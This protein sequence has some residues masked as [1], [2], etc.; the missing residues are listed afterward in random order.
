MDPAQS[1]RSPCQGCVEIRQRD[2]DETARAARRNRAGFCLPRG[3]KLLQLHHR[4]NP[5]DHRR[6]FRG[7]RKRNTWQRNG[8]T[9]RARAKTSK[10]R[11]IA[12]NA[13]TPRAVMAAKAARSRAAN[14]RSPSAFRKSARWARRFRV[15]S[16]NEIRNHSLLAEISA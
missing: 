14:R 10:E 15:K 5:A 8:N 1:G 3:A 7:L 2:A 6:L 9:R 4:R 16:R 13:A 12:T 11:Y